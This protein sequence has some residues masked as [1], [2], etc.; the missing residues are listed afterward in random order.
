MKCCHVLLFRFILCILDRS[1][2]ERNWI[3]GSTL[4]S[5][6][7]K[8]T[9]RNNHFLFHLE[10]LA[11]YL[12]ASF[13]VFH[14]LPPPWLLCV[15][16]DQT[17]ITLA[18]SNADVTVGEGTRMQCA[19]SHDTSLEIAFVWS[20]NGRVIDLSEDSRHFERTS[21]S[22]HCGQ[23]FFGGGFILGFTMD[24]EGFSLDSLLWPRPQNNVEQRCSLGLRPF[25][26]KLYNYE[27]LGLCLWSFC[28]GNG[29]S[30]DL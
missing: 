3:Y 16:A 8:C 7:H 13:L 12:L 2:L 30:R 4:P 20:L 5:S 10:I 22:C 1:V 15:S 23:A 27:Y 25:Q 11:G 17:K 21:V 19:A 14:R 6:G 29:K 9:L 24:C 28:M 18:P 26:V